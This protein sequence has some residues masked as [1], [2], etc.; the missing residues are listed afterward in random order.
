MYVVVVSA[1]DF[2]VDAKRLVDEQGRDR[3]ALVRDSYP[4]CVLLSSTAP[5]DRAADTRP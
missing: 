2:K 1:N 3:Q 5:G 4:W